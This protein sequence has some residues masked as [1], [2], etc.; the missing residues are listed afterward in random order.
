M[1]NQIF[2]NVTNYIEPYSPVIMSNLSYFINLTVNTYKNITNKITEINNTLKNNFG[3]IK[4]D[5]ELLTYR[6]NVINEKFLNSKCN[7]NNSLSNLN[8]NYLNYAK[9]YVNHFEQYEILINFSQKYLIL[10]DSVDEIFKKCSNIENDEK[11]KITYKICEL[12]EQIGVLNKFIE[13]EKYTDI[14]FVYSTLSLLDDSI[15]NIFKITNNISK[16]KIEYNKRNKPYCSKC[17]RKIYKKKLQTKY[18]KIIYT[19]LHNKCNFK[20]IKRK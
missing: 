10:L 14:P 8:N 2:E 4:T 5:K 7:L 15:D 9:K 6:N 16:Y 3:I 1:S 12:I 19:K 13:N 17:S 11:I 20:I 18:K